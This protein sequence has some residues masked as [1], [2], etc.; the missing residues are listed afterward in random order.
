MEQ[1]GRDAG[2]QSVIW[3]A[4]EM[5]AEI[6]ASFDGTFEEAVTRTMES[7]SRSGTQLKAVFYGGNKVVRIM[8]ARQ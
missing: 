2:W 7:L 1:W 3:E 8:E 5:I 4:P 6:G